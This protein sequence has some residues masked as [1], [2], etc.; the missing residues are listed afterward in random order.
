VV[1]DTCILSWLPQP[2]EMRCARILPVTVADDRAGAVRLDKALEQFVA[3][4][5]QRLEVLTR[6]PEVPLPRQPVRPSPGSVLVAP[7][8]RASQR[9]G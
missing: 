5:Q 4:G 6:R 8:L 2:P 3:L 7:I 1:L 9:A